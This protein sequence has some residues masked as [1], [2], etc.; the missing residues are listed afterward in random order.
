MKGHKSVKIMF[1]KYHIKP[2]YVLLTALLLC[3]CSQKM[4]SLGITTSDNDVPAYSASDSPDL[5]TSTE[6][7][8]ESTSEKS[9]AEET[10]T[11]EST[12][13]ETAAEEP[14]TEE[15]ATEEP[16]QETTTEASIVFYN[17]DDVMYVTKNANVRMSPSLDAPIYRVFPAG[18]SVQCV[19]KSEEWYVI[20]VDTGTYYIHASLL[21]LENPQAESTEA[22]T[23]EATTASSVSVN[24]NGVVTNNGTL[25][26]IGDGPTVCIDAGHQANGNSST[27]P[28]GPGSTTMKAKVTTGTSGVASGLK[29]SQLNL[30]VSCQLRDE[31]LSRGYNVLM[32]RET[33]DVDLSNAQRAQMATS[34]GADI[35]I[36][37]HANGSDNASVSGVLTMSPTASNPYVAALYPACHALSSCVVNAIYAQTGAVNR[38]IS[39]T[40]TMS[41]INWTTMPVTI[42]EMGYMTNP[43]EDLL[44]A[45]GDYQAKIV[46]GI[47]NGIDTYFG[48]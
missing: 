17:C 8:A 21:S 10:A 5:I 16:T 33:Q 32:I 40:D 35:F 25:Y 18:T 1:R 12:T 19:A 42:V 36:R 39:E 48:R 31:L 46:T 9:T 37:I 15:T 13:E 34:G 26:H 14:T 23:E 45:S 28:N 4:P 11:N 47:A 44:M 24:P 29:E 27:E 3:G 20:S 41:G 7:I 30:L 2:C 38:G 43:T 6:R 22:Q